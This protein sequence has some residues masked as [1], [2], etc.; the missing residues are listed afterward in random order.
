MVMM[1]MPGRPLWSGS[2][3][4]CSSPLLDR[5]PGEMHA[6]VNGFLEAASILILYDNYY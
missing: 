3:R 2:A 6:S 4:R 5:R 1:M